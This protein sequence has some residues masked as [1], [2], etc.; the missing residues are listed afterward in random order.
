MTAPNYHMWPYWRDKYYD[1]VEALKD[2][3][4]EV[5]AAEEALR[6]EVVRI[7]AYKALID[8]I[9]AEHEERRLAA[10]PDAVPMWS[11]HRDDRGYTGALEAHYMDLLAVTEP[12]RIALQN[13]MDA[14]ATIDRWMTAK[15]EAAASADS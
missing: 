10:D 11:S 6:L 9:M 2:Y 3:Y 5:L 1:V 15:A 7:S 14:R 13:I 4:P 12:L 8:R